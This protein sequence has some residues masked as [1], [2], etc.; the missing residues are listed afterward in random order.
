MDSGN[1]APDSLLAG[2]TP[3]R[4]S[5]P[6][7]PGQTGY[8]IPVSLPD[9]PS[10]PPPYLEHIVCRAVQGEACVQLA[11]QTAERV[12]KPILDAPTLNLHAGGGGGGG[13]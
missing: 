9:A 8:S 11:G 10:A 5:R 7:P 12:L 6:P 4:N 3:A 2:V 1:S 13:A